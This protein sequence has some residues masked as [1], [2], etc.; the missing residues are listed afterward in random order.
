[1][2]YNLV[3]EFIDLSKPK[4]RRSPS[5]YF[6]RDGR[7]IKIGITNNV[8]SRLSSLQT[9][10]PRQLKLLGSFKGTARDE[11]ELH[12]KFWR[13]RGLGEWFKDTAE[14]QTV[15]RDRCRPANDNVPVA[16][17]AKVA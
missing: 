17:A 6:V 16:Q 3:G 13:D 12:D 4:P 5:V 8:S 15:I 7:S 1:V 9:G 14:L 2:P 11:A 10:N